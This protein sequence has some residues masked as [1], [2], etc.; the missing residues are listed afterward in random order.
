MSIAKEMLEDEV[1][2]LE[3]QLNK[4]I[5]ALLKLS[6]AM[7]TAQIEIDAQENQLKDLKKILNNNYGKNH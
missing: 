7:R 5:K 1:K 3:T 4:N 2:K 6:V